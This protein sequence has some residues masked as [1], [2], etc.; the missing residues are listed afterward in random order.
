MEAVS[1]PGTRIS[2]PPR[3]SSHSPGTKLIFGHEAPLN[4][5]SPRL[6]ASTPH[7]KQARIEP[8]SAAAFPVPP[9]C[10]AARRALS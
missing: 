4:V 6:A 1:Q 9:R 7:S 3:M 10:L 2:V 8:L 5:R